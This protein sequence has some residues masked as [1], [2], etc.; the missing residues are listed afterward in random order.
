MGDKPTRSGTANTSATIPQRIPVDAI[1]NHQLRDIAIVRLLHPVQISDAIMPI[2]LPS[3]DVAPTSF[4]NPELHQCIRSTSRSS[5]TSSKVH[6]TRVTTIVVQPLAPNDC[7]ILLSRKGGQLANDEMCAWDDPGDTCTR[8]LGGPLS[9]QING[10]HHVVGLNSFV[11]FD[12]S[13]NRNYLI[14]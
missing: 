1:Y 9:V 10:R 5:S 6:Q 13:I 3:E 7:R 14:I 4:N 12:V 8:D 2:C 11:N